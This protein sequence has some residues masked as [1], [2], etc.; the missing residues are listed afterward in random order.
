M[1]M[2]CRAVG[3]RL[4]GRSKI[5]GGEVAL[6]GDTTLVA[7]HDASIS[8][9]IE[10]PIRVLDLCHVGGGGGG[11][12]RILLR[13]AATIDPS[14]VA[15]TVCCIRR[16]GDTQFDLD[17]RAAALGI[18]Y[19][20]IVEK[21]R[22]DH[23]VMSA[24]RAILRERRPMIVHTHQYK[25]SYFAW[26]QAAA[27]GAI[28]MAT[29][30]GWSGHSW[31]ELCLYYPADK[32]LV[33]R[34]PMILAVSS[35]I[36]DTLLRWGC[37]P[38][39]VR[40]I[41]NGI[42]PAEFRRDEQVRL[43]IRRELGV[44]P[45]EVV[46]GAVG[47]LEREKRYD[48]ILHTVSRLR[49]QGRD[50]RLFLAGDG[51]LRG[52]I[53]EEIHQLGLRHSCQVLGYR[54]DIT[55]LYQ[56]FDVFVQS[57]DN[58]GTPTVICEAMAMEIPVVATNAGG[59]AELAE[60]GVHALI[61]PIRRPDLLAEAIVRTISDQQATARR[62]AAARHRVESDLSFDTRTRKLEGVYR[63]VLESVRGTARPVNS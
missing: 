32:R 18:D 40:V 25:A 61:V 47:R 60:H 42:D 36:R 11:V 13:T 35:H 6:I 59:T 52:D 28:P 26:R 21:S 53:E 22:F 19:C 46:L 27:E 45:G 56:A 5:T 37:K 39:R 3:G 2:S 55:R 24:L 49:A 10:E 12:D 54:S 7:L 50:V 58:E 1:E 51:S 38:D 62:V 8:E 31:R 14:R 17:R 23:N 44:D 20:E 16:A 48:V 57:S 30:H 41:L 34:F 29:C 43:D 33:G 63:D 9:T 4:A 15:M